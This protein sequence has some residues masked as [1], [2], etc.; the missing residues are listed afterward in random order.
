MDGF[1]LGASRHA[2]QAYSG[3]EKRIRE[4]GNWTCP[5]CVF[6]NSLRRTVCVNCPTHT[7]AKDEAGGSNGYRSTDSAPSHSRLHMGDHNGKEGPIEVKQNR[8]PVHLPLQQ[9]ENAR[10]TKK[11]Q[12]KEPGLSR[13]LWAPRTS[14][15]GHKSLNIGQVWTRVCFNCHIMISIN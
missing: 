5:V 13:S 7:T 9:T 3:N 11:L 4:P 6:S 12:L 8:P 15:G 10:H 14:S 2:P 1:G